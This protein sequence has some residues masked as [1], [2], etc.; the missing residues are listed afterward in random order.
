MRSFGFFTKLVCLSF[1]LVAL[2]LTSCE[3][4]QGQTGP[5][6][7]NGVNGKDGAN[8]KD[9]V[10]GKNGTDGKDGVNG[11][12]G[13]AN[14]KSFEVN[15]TAADW[16]RDSPTFFY[17]YYSNPD[18]T[19]AARAGGL[20]MAY[21][22]FQAGNAVYTFPLERTDGTITQSV[23]MSSGNPNTINFGFL[24]TSGNTSNPGNRSYKII[25]VYPAALK[26]RPNF[27]WSNYN[28]VAKE[29]HLPLTG[30]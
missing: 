13:N 8:G 27:N 28:T 17:A 26:A 18:I 19:D 24:D 3:G 22:V 12:D 21:T 25:I 9:G 30:R 1:V 23:F 29:F 16:N 14:V 11:K 2:T 7:T 6:G 5:Q 20:I 15:F 10:N 4:P